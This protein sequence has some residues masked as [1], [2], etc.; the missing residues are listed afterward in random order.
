LHDFTG[1]PDGAF[2]TGNLIS[3]SDGNFYGTTI[4]G[5]GGCGEYGSGTVFKIGPDGSEMVLYAFAGCDASS[6]GCWPNGGLVSDSSGNLYGT[7]YICGTANS[8]TVFKVK[9]NGQES[10]LYSFSGG[11]DGSYPEGSLIIDASG[12]LYGTTS[13]GGNACQIKKKIFGCGVVFKISTDGSETVLYAFKNDLDGMAPYAGLI[14]DSLGDFFGTTSEGGS[15][16]GCD[17]RHCGTIFELSPDGAKT[18]IYNFSKVGNSGELPQSNLISDSLG[19]LYGM[20]VNGGK[21]DCGGQANAKGC[22][23]IFKL[24][25]SLKPTSGELKNTGPGHFA[26]SQKVM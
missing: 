14:Q 26:R 22:G 25:L 6:D 3:D 19:N 5:G 24:G 4:Y 11:S 15:A 20:T 16:K 17:S 2:P 9:P 23:V 13:E 12:N 1:I 10:V 18:T 7:T 21:G 8:G